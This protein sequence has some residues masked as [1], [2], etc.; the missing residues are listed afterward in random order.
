MRREIGPKKKKNLKIAE[1]EVAQGRN[2]PQLIK[3]KSKIVD[4]LRFDEKMW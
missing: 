1:L 3:L 2:D 4:L